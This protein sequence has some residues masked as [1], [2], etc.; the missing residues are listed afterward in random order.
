M[1]RILF[2]LGFMVI[3]VMGYSQSPRTRPLPKR[4][5]EATAPGQFIIADANNDGQWDTTMVWTGTELLLNGDTVAVYPLTESQFVDL[6]TI[7]GDTLY[8]SISQDGVVPVAVNL[9]P[10][11]D[12]T[13]DQQIETFNLVG[14]TLT[15]AIENDGQP[16]QTVD[17]SG[18]LDNTDAQTL[19]FDD[20]TRILSISGGNSVDLSEGIQDEVNSLL[21]AGTNITLTYN[22]AGNTLTID[23]AGG[24]VGTDDQT[25]DTLS[26]TGTVLTLALEDDNEAPYTVDLASLQDGTGTDDQTVDTLSLTGTVLTLALEDD[27]EAPYTVDLASLQDGTGTDDQTVD[28]LSLTGTVLTLALEDDNEA[29]YT[30][31]LSSLQDGTGTDDQTVDTLSLTGTVLTLALEDDNE[32]PYTVDLASLQDG[33]GTDDQQIE[34][35]TLAANILTLALENDGQPNQTVNLSAYANQTLSFSTSTRVL[36]IS[37]GN[38][39]DMSEGIQD[40]VNAL[41]VGGTNVT[42][43]YND[44]GNTL[45]IN[46]VGDGTGTD[47]QQIETFSLVGNTLTLA[48]E[49]DGQPDQTLDLSGYLDNTDDQTVDTLSLTGTV[50]T[51]ALEDDNEAPYTVDLATLQDGTGTD[52]QNITFDDATRILAIETGNSQDLSEGI[53][54][55]VNAMLVGGT[56][57]TLTYNDGANTL[58]IDA[59]GGGGGSGNDLSAIIDTINQ[60]GHGFLSADIPIPVFKNSVTSNWEISVNS[61]ERKVHQAFVVDVINTNEFAIQ[62]EGFLFKTGHGYEVSKN[63]FLQGTAQVYDTIVP[64]NELNDWLWYAADADRLILKATRPYDPA[65]NIAAA[66]Q[67]V[68]TFSLSGT[69]L[70]LA[71]ENDNEAP[72]TV[73]LAS[74]A[75]GGGTDD[76]TVDTLSLTGTVLTLT[77]EDDNEAPYTV[78][79]SSLQ[80]GTGTDNQQ[81]ETF[82]LAANILTLALEDDGQ[83]NQTV[84]LSAYLDN[85]D[86]QTVDTL[87]LTGTVLTL[88]LE[89]D[90]EAPYTVDLASLQDGIGTD[91]QT[92]TFTD[93]TRVL[94]IESGNTVDLSEGIQ[95]EV[96][97]LLVAGTGIT[98]T[99]N[100]AGNTM[101]AAT[102]EVDAS[103]FAATKNSTLYLF[104]TLAYNPVTGW[105]QDEITSDFTFNSTTGELTINSTGV[106]MVSISCMVKYYIFDGG[107]VELNLATAFDT[108]S[109]FSTT[110]E[111]QWFS[112]AI[113]NPSEPDEG[114]VN[115]TYVKSFTT[116]DKIRIESYA[117]TQNVGTQVQTDQDKVRFYVTK[118]TK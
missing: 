18:Y 31:D 62:T 5:H 21:V 47:D 52:D 56:N 28:T 88:T 79:L 14:N 72:Y 50:L 60:V 85:T 30:V 58:T 4:I 36:S 89:D 109:G 93:A 92:L 78:D 65:A 114:G 26:L 73:D 70:T 3:S 34:T 25:V 101:T 102:S 9:S 17:L 104:D 99:Y 75:G 90:N 83:P 43:T 7:S 105:D 6:F 45:T 59:V 46:A 77:L 110:N 13:D 100:D 55:E 97:A 19:T 76:Q 106:Y 82:T 39:V 37:G 24:G 33:T 48:L 95:D 118:L 49:N 96:N 69:I 66:G 74:L 38:S 16:D 42:L 107:R 117:D 71:L 2:F 116:G 94:S 40:E 91:D 113:R 68:D 115:A 10:Y 84:N 80:D 22:D 112:Y 81:I 86:D 63:Y 12:N 15:L 11:L 98:L 35:F 51:L 1:K 61:N 27:N 23:A 57:V 67:T 111:H 53:Q 32:A 108:G 41:L 29:P 20:L 54:E 87:S 64:L 8:L 103:Y 44:A